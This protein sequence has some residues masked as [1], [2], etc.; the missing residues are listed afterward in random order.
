MGVL[1]ERFGD[2]GDGAMQ[3]LIPPCYLGRTI[4]DGTWKCCRMRIQLAGS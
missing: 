1:Y 4:K 3:L 2:L